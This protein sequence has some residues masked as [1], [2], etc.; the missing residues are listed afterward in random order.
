VTHARVAR[1]VVSGNAQT[2]AVQI[3]NEFLEESRLVVANRNAVDKDQ[4]FGTAEDR[5]ISELQETS[6][7]D[8]ASDS[9]GEVEAERALCGTAELAERGDEGGLG[10]GAH[11]QDHTAKGRNG[12]WLAPRTLHE[13]LAAAP[14]PSFNQAP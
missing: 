12:D 5:F 2:S 14:R 9:L 7:A 1:E 3:G 10:G 6:G 11:R 8:S 13:D 4:V